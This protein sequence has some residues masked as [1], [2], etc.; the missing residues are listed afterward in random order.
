[1]GEKGA[2]RQ[3]L[4]TIAGKCDQWREKFVNIKHFLFLILYCEFV[5]NL[6]MLGMGLFQGWSHM[7]SSYYW[8]RSGIAS[9]SIMTMF[10]FGSFIG[11]ILCGFV[12][13]KFGRKMPLSY[14]FIL[15]TVSDS[16][17]HP[18]KENFNKRFRFASIQVSCLLSIFAGSSICFQISI[19][20]A[21]IFGGAM[22]NIAPLYLAEISNDR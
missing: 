10:A 11:T 6:Y 22:Q 2:Q 15:I 21:G 8:E 18:K 3:Y 7:E 9:I 16:I 5:V 20:L 17:N 19:L 14:A 13:I 12:S 4:A 1:M